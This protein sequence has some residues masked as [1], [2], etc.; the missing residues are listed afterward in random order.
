M[1]QLR[2]K[3]CNIFYIGEMGQM[4]LKRVSG[5]QSTSM[6]INLPVPIHTQSHQLPF[7]EC[8]SVSV[9]HKLLDAT[10]TISATNLKQHVNLYF[11]PD[12]LTVSTSNNLTRLPPP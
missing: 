5:H 11:K 1:Y 7:Q 2:C 3:K 8:W 9:I 12:S 4:L 10:P 6:V